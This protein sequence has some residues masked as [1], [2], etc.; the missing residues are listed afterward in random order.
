MLG[1]EY[2]M[3]K[4]WELLKTHRP[5]SKELKIR[6]PVELRLHGMPTNL[7]GQKRQC[8]L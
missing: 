2:R 7:E 4:S 5:Y 3:Q 8:F 6:G 1:P